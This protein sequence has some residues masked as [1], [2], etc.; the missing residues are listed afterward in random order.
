VNSFVR[1]VGPTHALEVYGVKLVGINAANANKL[2]FTL[3]FY[4]LIVL[5]RRA[6]WWLSRRLTGDLGGGRGAFWSREA[7]RLSTTVVLILGLVS[8]WFDDPTRLTTALGLVTAGLAFA[9]QK[10]VTAVAGYFVILRGKTFNVG[11]RISMGGVRGDVIALGFIQTTIME[12]GQPPAVQ[13]ADPAQWVRARQYSGRIVTVTND[14]IFD[15]PV[16]N[17]T[18]D[19]PYIW[20]EMHL[21]ITYTADRVKAERILLDAAERHTVP[22]ATLSREALEE[23]ERRYF[24]KPAEMGPRVYYRLTDNWL[25]LTVRFICED[26]KIR[27]LKDAMSREIITS[28]DAAGI[29]IASSTYDIVGLPP[30]RLE[31]DPKTPE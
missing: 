15:N 6:L 10:V 20:D 28:L 29:G 27:D 11:D 8:I 24:M 18:R 22:I 21:P 19:F 9:L 3:I 4:L 2:L 13:D 1:F 7:I 14:K 16:Y 23:M 5:L 26:H 17:Y 30:I 12:M 31:R 25:E